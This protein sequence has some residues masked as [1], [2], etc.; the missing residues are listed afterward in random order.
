MARHRLRFTI[1]GETTRARSEHNRT[2]QSGKATD[3]M[4]QDRTCEIIEAHRVKPA[5]APFPE[6][7]DRVDQ[8]GDNGTVDQI[9]TELHAARDTAGDNRRR[10]RCKG[11]LEQKIDLRMQDA[12]RR[13]ISH[14]ADTDTAPPQ[15]SADYRVP[16]HQPITDQIVQQHTDTQIHHILEQ[17]VDGIL[18]RVKSRLN[19]GEAR[20]HEDHQHRAKEKEEIINRKR[21]ERVIRRLYDNGFLHRHLLSPHRHRHHHQGSDQRPGQYSSQTTFHLFLLILLF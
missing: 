1:L 12:R 21:R 13:C 20:L 10:R 6:P 19:H 2:R 16:V 14:L 18:R 17:N 7:A 3:R 9:R 5:A 8:T 11:H 15:E 4:H